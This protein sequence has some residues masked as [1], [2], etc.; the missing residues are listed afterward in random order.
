MFNKIAISLSV[1]LM[2][3]GTLSPIAIND[4][5]AKSYGSR[6]QTKL[7]RSISYKETH[8]YWQYYYIYKCT[9]RET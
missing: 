8:I 3:M 6:R 7:G 9:K 5:E 1:A 2:T 4:A